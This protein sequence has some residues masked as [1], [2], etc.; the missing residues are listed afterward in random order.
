MN[1]P[2][3]DEMAGWSLERCRHEI[4]KLRTELAFIRGDS[5]RGGPARESDRTAIQSWIVAIQKHIETVRH[6]N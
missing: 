1:F 5:A 6:G 2:D 4:M 3:M